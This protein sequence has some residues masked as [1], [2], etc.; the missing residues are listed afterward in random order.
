MNEIDAERLGRALAPKS[1]TFVRF[2]CATVGIQPLGSFRF[3]SPPHPSPRV[4]KSLPS[5][6]VNIPLPC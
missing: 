5:S 4:R 3:R 6:Y 1:L 2:G